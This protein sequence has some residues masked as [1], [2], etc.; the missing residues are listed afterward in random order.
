MALGMG[1]IYI[2]YI[3]RFWG[4]MIKDDEEEEEDDDHHQQQHFY[5]DSFKSY[6]NHFSIN[7]YLIWLSIFMKKYGEYCNRVSYLGSVLFSFPKAFTV[8][9]FDAFVWL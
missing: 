3:D 2:P 9:R 8:I 7:Y 4:G 5:L 6:Q 1:F